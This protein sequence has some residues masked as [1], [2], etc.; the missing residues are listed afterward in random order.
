MAARRDGS[1]GGDGTAAGGSVGVA[2]T[3]AAALGVAAGAVNGVGWLESDTEAAAP[4]GEMDAEAAGDLET[5]DPTMASAATSTTAAAAAVA[6]GLR[7]AGGGTR[8]MLRS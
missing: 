7:R 6:A 5:A 1:A 3:V 2:V 8:C 4:G